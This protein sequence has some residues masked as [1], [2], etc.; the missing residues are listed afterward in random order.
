MSGSG[1]QSLTRFAAAMG[2]FKCFQLELRRGYGMT[3]FRE[4]LKVGLI[5]SCT[6]FSAHIVHQFS[7]FHTDNWCSRLQHS[8]AAQDAQACGSACMGAVCWLP[9]RQLAAPHLGSSC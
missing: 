6:A 3:E 5:P 4:D 9:R 7:A 1:K 2:G 8:A